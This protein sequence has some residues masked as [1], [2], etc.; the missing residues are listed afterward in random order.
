MSDRS[1]LSVGLTS[2][3]RDATGWTIET[4]AGLIDS[5]ISSD[6]STRILGIKMKFGT[7]VGSTDNISGFIDGEGKVTTSIR[8]GMT[9]QA[10]LAGGIT[11][12]LRWVG[13]GG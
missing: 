9:V 4:Q 1:A 5:H 13:F 2:S 3:R 7:A 10:E 12:R 11:I 8:A 6:W